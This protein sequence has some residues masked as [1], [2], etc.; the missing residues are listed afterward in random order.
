MSVNLFAPRRLPGV[1]LFAVIFSFCAL[2]LAQIS[3]V[4]QQAVMQQP[5]ITQAVDETQLTV[6][7]GNT[8]PLAR[9]QFDL[10][11]APA[12][13][14]M[15]RMLLVL[16]RSAAQEA[17]LRK[18][19]DDQQDKA[20]P[21]YH[22]WRTPEQFGRQF[23]PTDA[24]MQTITGWLQA[25]GFQV[26]STKGRTVLEFSGSASQVQE[27]FHT[28]IHKYLV[29]EEQHWA[30]ASDP[31]IPTALTPA[32][33][34]V[35]TLH[36]FLSKPQVHFDPHPVPVKFTPGKAPYVTFPAQNGQPI[37]YALGPQDY[38][39]IYDINPVYNGPPA[40]QGQ[41][42]T[43][44]I[45][46]RS[47]LF[48]VNQAGDVD[49][50]RFNFNLPSI[51]YPVV[52][53]GP[54]PGD[55][56]GVEELEATLDV[57]WSG[58]VA[59]LATL[60]FVVSATT[61]TTD[62]I[63][64]SEAYIVENNF[65]DVMT[66]S[67]GSCEF[68]NTDARIAGTNALAEQAAA[69]GITYFVSAGD[70]GAEGCDSNSETLATG[71]IS[72]NMFASTPFTVAVGGTM[73]NENGQDATYWSNAAP[74][75]ETAISY[76][77]E[78]VWNESC[79]TSSCQSIL[80]GSGGASAGNLGN[81]FGGTTPGIPK[82]SWQSVV[83][84]IPNDK[85]RDIPDVSLTSAGHDPYLLCVAGS[86]GQGF[87]YF[88]YGTSAAA[89]S[90]AGI[91]A[92]VDSAMANLGD[93]VRQGQ[94][95]YMLYP[96]A[97]TQQAA[98]TACDA[99]SATLPNN[100]CVFN[101]VTVGNNSVP[102]EAGYPNGVYSAGVGYDLASGLGSVNVANLVTAWTGVSFRPTSTTLKLNGI[103][104]GNT[105]PINVTHGTSI[106]V[107]ITVAPTSRTGTPT[108]DVSLIAA[109]G[110]SPSPS[111]KTGIGDFTLGGTGTV[112]GT[113]NQLPGGGPYYVTAHYAGNTTNTPTGVFAPSDSASPG[114]QVTVTQENST[115]TE[116]AF[117]YDQNG[118]SIPL[119]G[120]PF[121]SFVFVRAD[122][123]S[124]ANPTTECQG[125]I[126]GAC[127]TG[128][129]TFTDTCNGTPCNLP[130]QIFNPVANP[131]ALNSQGNTSIGAGVINFDAGNHSI[132]VSYAGDASFNPSNSGAPVTFSI[133]PGFAGVSGPTNV[134][135]TSPGLSGSST[136]GI[137]TSTGFTTA[138]SFTCAGLPAE[139]AC[140]STPVTGSGPNTIVNATI[141]VTTMGPH[142]T[143]LAPN[144]RPYY[145][146]A[147]CAGA[148]P[149]VG[150]LMLTGPRR[151]SSALLGLMA[152]TMLA[153]LSGCGGG[154]SS[155]QQD[156]G[157]PAGTYT[158]TVTATAGSLSQQGTLTLTVK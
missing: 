69:Q 45:V 88:V 89:P 10:G 30:N 130:G 112:S 94:A 79:E 18:L 13:L 5:L 20:S 8:H 25:H 27:A 31:S 33:G 117:A 16:K 119:T 47:N 158:V 49:D 84:G 34:G 67:F 98:G 56:G 144:N 62:G 86:C 126:V 39:T 116:T 103:A 129:V 134:T 139:A 68:F 32:V 120:I 77:P 12:A 55:L 121:G 91:M 85:V 6:L 140:V 93:S 78:D 131:V 95:D 153:T 145:L 57:T 105:T 37:T 76:I 63:D 155:H 14:P 35:L 53:D 114:V 26:G 73:F 51:G 101:D 156:P 59:P 142:T 48:G 135:V 38:A 28:T 81:G 118:N 100:G 74:L 149:L 87:I 107:G 43:I 147:V 46:G 4:E 9:P 66:E 109:I 132:S 36:N 128:M 40:N 3:S 124:A 133:Q 44:G 15:Q 2:S 19:L 29:D 136:V 99:S 115:T 104:S 7:K 64:L 52:L 60:E 58:A 151:R 70:T 123:A 141:T 108:G 23:G 72:I 152:L 125:S 41:G 97:A 110:S 83:T 157:T 22:K 106:N 71:P 138:V 137:I 80:A 146:A 122:V 127:P 42:V 24:D 148:L 17:A 54:D 154:G 143:M 113:T 61:N 1:T 102:G 150:M 111:P 50:F 75:A 65:A 96:L 11:T 90:F 92:L 82:P 21:N